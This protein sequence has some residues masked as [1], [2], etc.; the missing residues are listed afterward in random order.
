MVKKVVGL[1]VAAALIL[2]GVLVGAVVLLTQV[3]GGTNALSDAAGCGEIASPALS[4]DESKIPGD[5]DKLDKEQLANLAIIMKVGKEEGMSEK[6]QLVAG[7][8]AFQESTLENL[9]SGDRDSLG[10][11]QQRPSQSWGTPD[12]LTTPAYAARAFYKGVD[13]KNGSHVP[14]LDDIKG[15][16]KM[17][18]ND[19]AQ[20]VQNSNYP[21]EYG[22]H[23]ATIRAGMAALADVPVTDASTSLTDG[24]LGCDTDALAAAPEGLPTQKQLT[25]DSASVSCPKGTSDL[26]P[27]SGGFEGKHIPVRLCSIHDT[28]CTGSDCGKGQLGGK[29]RGEVVLNSLVAPHFIAWLKEVR[30]K[31][32]D[33]QFSSSFRS[34]ETQS[35]LSGSSNAARNGY[36]NH[37]MGAAVDI[38]GMSG[39]YTRN[40]CTGHTSDGACK[41]DDPNWKTYHD[42]GLKNGGDFHD[43]EFWHIEWVIT[44]GDDRNIPFLNKD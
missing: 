13:A 27:A 9:K 36:S 38:S 32:A 28:V 14:G 11:F 40:N 20:E 4:V 3:I 5:V 31:G 19:A 22:D 30:S 18:L 7:M 25:S 33:P 17:T 35:R 34:W 21:D 1:A 42:A 29:A 8:T 43:Q 44:R 24:A 16:E 12:E 15:W 10:L 41:S 37:Q 26:G 6:A 39:S 2:A 23:E